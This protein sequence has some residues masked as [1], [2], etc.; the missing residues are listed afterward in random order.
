MHQ[1]YA[2]RMSEISNMKAVCII[3]YNTSK[4]NKLKQFTIHYNIVQF[5]TIQLNAVQYVIKYYNTIKY[6]RIQKIALHYKT[7]Y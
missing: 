6:I 3:K 1:I 4:Y 5:I 2:Q 7:I